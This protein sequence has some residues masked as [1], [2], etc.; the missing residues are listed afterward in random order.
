MG[1]FFMSDHIN[2]KF[3]D[4]I[5]FMTTSDVWWLELLQPKKNYVTEGSMLKYSSNQIFPIKQYSPLLYPL[6]LINAAIK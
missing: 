4:C 1:P 5:N 6:S 3:I 2:V